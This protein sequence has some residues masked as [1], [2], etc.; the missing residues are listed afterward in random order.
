MGTGYPLGTP[1]VG[2]FLVRCFG[3]VVWC[4]VFC[5]GHLVRLKGATVFW[6]WSFGATERCDCFL[7][8]G[9]LVRLKGATVFWYGHLVRIPGESVSVATDPCQVARS[10]AMDRYSPKIR[11]KKQSHLSVA[12]ND[13]TKKQ[14]HLSVAPKDQTVPKNR[15]RT[16]QSHQTTVPKKSR[17]FQSHQMTVPFH[18]PRRG[19]QGTHRTVPGLVFG[20]IRAL[21]FS[22]ANMY[23]YYILYIYILYYIVLYIYIY[24]YIYIY[25]ILYIYTYIYIYMYAHM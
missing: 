15:S 7:V 11:T 12:P 20:S 13:R 21:L 19:K 10:V 8:Y 5:Y 1:S 4:D 9:H 25:I 24:T 16:F 6:Y 18:T 22:L 23:I 14:S 17:T 2:C 3:A